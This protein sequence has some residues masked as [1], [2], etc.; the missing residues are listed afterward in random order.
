MCHSV[1][2]GGPL[3]DVTSYLAAWFHVPYGGVSVSGLRS[4]LE[5]VSVQGDIS[6]GGVFIQGVSLSRGICLGGLCLGGLCPW[7]PMDRD[8]QTGDSQDNFGSLEK[9]LL[10]ILAM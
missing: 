10:K 5:G 6:L 2:G 9:P 3:Y 7:A 1:H 4:F 8:T